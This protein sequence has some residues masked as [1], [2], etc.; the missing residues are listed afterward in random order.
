VPRSRITLMQVAP[1]VSIHLILIGLLFVGFS[2]VALGVAGALFF[3]RMFV[4]TAFYHRYF[5]HRSFSTHR[6]T[7]FVFA[8]IGT[9]S[10]QRG[11]IWWA[12]HHREHHRHSDDEHDTHSPHRHGLLWS[13]MGWFLSEDGFKINWKAVPD[14]AKYPELVWLEKHNL[15]GPV[16]LAALIFGLGSL[17]SWAAPSLGTSGWQMLVWGFGVSTVALYHATFTINSIAHVIGKR[18]FAT[19]DDSRNN[20]LLA[21][22]TLGEGWH[23]NHHYF[24]GSARQGFYWW[25]I[26]ISY[27]ILRGMQAVG[28][29]WGVRPVPARVYEAAERHRELVAPAGRR[30]WPSFLPPR[31]R[32]DANSRGGA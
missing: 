29:V 8:L 12:A 32:S 18:R 14:W 21:L 16:G 19:K 26:D 13:H 10:A 3:I 30:R 17:L 5:S 22:L 2:W 27:Y 11:P 4:I 25:E 24:P 15:I 28:L 23:N 1:Y 7:Q 9:S 31:A 6:V 20:L